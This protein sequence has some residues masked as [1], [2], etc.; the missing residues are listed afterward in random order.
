VDSAECELFDGSAQMAVFDSAEDLEAARLAI[1]ELDCPQTGGEYIALVQGESWL[2][3]PT[4]PDTGE[5]M[6]LALEGEFAP[7]SCR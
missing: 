1:S 7:I 3:R 6:A 4:N 2:V 5:D